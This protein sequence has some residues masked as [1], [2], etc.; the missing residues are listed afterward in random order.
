MSD[1]PFRLKFEGWAPVSCAPSSM[2]KKGQ[3]HK[4]PKVGSRNESFGDKR[5][6]EDFQ[7]VRVLEMPFYMSNR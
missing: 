1:R 2:R 3:A 7:G 5:E 6:W 4:S